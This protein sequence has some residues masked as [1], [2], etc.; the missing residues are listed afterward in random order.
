M[1]DRFERWSRAEWK[2]IHGTLGGWL[3]LMTGPDRTRVVFSIPWFEQFVFYC[4]G[5]RRYGA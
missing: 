3:G 4:S 5:S 2:S 1:G